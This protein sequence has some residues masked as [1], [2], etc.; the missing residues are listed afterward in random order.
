MILF[1]FACGLPFGFGGVVNELV[2]VV[3]ADAAAADAE[4]E[5]LLLWLFP[6]PSSVPLMG[7]IVYGSAQLGRFVII[8]WLDLTA[9][10]SLRDASN[11]VKPNGIK[12]REQSGVVMTNFLNLSVQRWLK[13]V[14][15]HR[16]GFGDVENQFT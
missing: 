12:S 4:F 15:I 16:R 2:V 7:D 5:L 13:M 10:H 8:M 1:Y 3:A 6:S 14:E 9:I 11:H